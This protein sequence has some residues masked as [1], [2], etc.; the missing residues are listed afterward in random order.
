VTSGKVEAEKYRHVCQ[1]LAER[2]PNL[3]TIA[4]TLRASLS[5]SHNTWSGILGRTGKTYIGPSYDIIPIVDRVGAG[6]SFVAGLIYGLDR[7]GDDGQRI[8]DFAVAASALKHTIVGD[9]N[10][11]SVSEVEQLMGGDRSGR[12]RR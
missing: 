6:D 10:L 2:F 8:V 11:V 5:A 1:E 9:F 3:K 4:I 12:V 7:F